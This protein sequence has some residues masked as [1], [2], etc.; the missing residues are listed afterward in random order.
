M[1]VVTGVGTRAGAGGPGWGWG[2]YPCWNNTYYSYDEG[3]LTIDMID[4]EGTVIPPE[5]CE[6]ENNDCE[7]DVVWNAFIRGF[8]EFQ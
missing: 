1:V 5:G 8:F 6:G 7:L 3:S 2:S 4:V